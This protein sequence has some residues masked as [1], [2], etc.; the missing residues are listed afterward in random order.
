MRHGGGTGAGG[1]D[2][3]DPHR[4]PQLSETSSSTTSRPAKLHGGWPRRVGRAD[5]RRRRILG[6]ST[7]IFFK[8]EVDK[9]QAADVAAMFFTSG[10]TGNL[11]GVVHTHGS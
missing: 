1:Q 8:A 10:T 3:G 6:R 9:A 11:K 5:R 7:R 4:C 2:A